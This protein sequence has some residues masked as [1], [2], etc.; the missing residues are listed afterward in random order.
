[1]NLLKPDYLGGQVL[2]IA[3]QNV[4]NLNTQIEM[5]W[6][7]DMIHLPLINKQ[8]NCDLEN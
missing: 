2:F 6:Y 5:K 3:P 1:M 8:T 4:I 7:V